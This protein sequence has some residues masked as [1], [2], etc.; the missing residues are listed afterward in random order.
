MADKFIHCPE[1]DSTKIIT[2]DFDDDEDAIECEDCGWQGTE[3]EL[4]CAK[5][6]DDAE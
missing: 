5:S 3:G 4:V 6:E 1:C 2:C